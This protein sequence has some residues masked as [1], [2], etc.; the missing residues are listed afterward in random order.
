MNNR[1][2]AVQLHGLRWMSVLAAAF[3]PW[4]VCQA[5]SSAQPEDDTTAASASSAASAPA[6][7]GSGAST[8]AA[9]GSATGSGGMGG[10]GGEDGEGGGAGA[11][12]DAGVSPCSVPEGSVAAL[13]ALCGAAICLRSDMAAGVE[14]AV[15]DEAPEGTVL[16][17]R[18]VGPVTCDPK[19][20]GLTNG[21]R[22]ATST[23]NG[24]VADAGQ[25]VMVL[26]SLTV[27]LP[28]DDNVRSTTVSYV[29]ANGQA[30]KTWEI[31]IDHGR[32][33]FTA[34]VMLPFVFNGMRT[35]STAPFA[36]TTDSYIRVQEDWHITAALAL[37][38][39]PFGRTNGLIA[40]F[41]QGRGAQRI[42][43]NLAVQLAVDFDLENPL[44]E[45]YF[46]LAI[47]PVNGI[48]IGG[49]AALLERD[50]LPGSLR[51]G[52]LVPA[53]GLPA[54]DRRYMFAPYFSATL[55][56]KVIDLLRETAAAV[57]TDDEGED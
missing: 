43:D 22:D 53:D 57:D 25:G 52:M 40:P 35:I 6:S 2:H 56:L 15:P 10:G 16:E 42:L 4:L 54:M 37:T 14:V 28:E 32:T 11:A 47:E 24:A 30:A 44:D 39:Y 19:N 23:A 41:V 49:G 5:T 9:S 26:K 8:A 3:A 46:G 45:W 38:V 50:F 12:S 21:N 18:V 27:T 1:R 20:I 51:P 29:P 55:S 48:A 31:K 33:Y 17:F 34:G 13:T 7:S 36:G